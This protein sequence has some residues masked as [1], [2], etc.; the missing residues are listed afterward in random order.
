[1]LNFRG[2][3]RGRSI[4]HTLHLYESFLCRI[5]PRYAPKKNQQRLQNNLTTYSLPVSARGRSDRRPPEK[6]RGTSPTPP[7]GTVPDEP[8]R[9]HHC[10]R[11]CCAEVEVTGPNLLCA[12]FQ[13]I[14]YRGSSPSSAADEF[15]LNSSRKPV[16]AVGDTTIYK[17]VPPGGSKRKRSDS[18]DSLTEVLLFDVGG[19]G[20]K[21]H[22][23]KVAENRL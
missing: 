23:Y 20:I 8:M 12:R 13:R 16:G 19:C 22:M 21:P 3:T 10:S 11:C 9:V 7:P 2:P 1:M 4:Q 18:G 5:R 17:L 6:S 15:V 14:I